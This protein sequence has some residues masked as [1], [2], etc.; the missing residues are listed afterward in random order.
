MKNIKLNYSQLIGQHCYQKGDVVE[1]SDDRAKELVFKGAAEFH[2]VVEYETA[3][4]KKETFETPDK[5]KPRRKTK[6]T[7]E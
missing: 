2:S 4:M 1:V 7:G 3:D 5:P 6:K